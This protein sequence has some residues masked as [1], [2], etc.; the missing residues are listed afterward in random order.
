MCEF[1]YLS[2]LIRCFLISEIPQHSQNGWYTN[3]LEMIISN[4][5]MKSLISAFCMGE[6]LSRLNRV[7]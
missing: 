3:T 5:P 6:K 1:G 4:I 2:L 7:I